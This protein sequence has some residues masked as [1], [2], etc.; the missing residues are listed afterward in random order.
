MKEGEGSSTA[1]GASVLL[2]EIE[3]PDD[4]WVEQDVYRG[5]AVADTPPGDSSSD[6]GDWDSDDPEE[7]ERAP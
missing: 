2:R 7:R 4:F 3:E 1:N 5:A 6:E